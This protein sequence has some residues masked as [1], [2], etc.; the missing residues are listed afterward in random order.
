MGGR[1]ARAGRLQ[2][3]EGTDTMLPGTNILNVCVCVSLCVCVKICTYSGK[4]NFK[5]HFPPKLKAYIM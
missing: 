1:L 3:G 2:F 5:K 4:E